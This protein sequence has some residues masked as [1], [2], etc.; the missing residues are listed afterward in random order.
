MPVSSPALRGYVGGLHHPPI[1]DVGDLLW[2]GG[3]ELRFNGLA[4][5]PHKGQIL[6]GARQ[7]EVSADCPA[8]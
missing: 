2:I 8:E 7:I 6:A 1:R 3:N 5:R 4:I